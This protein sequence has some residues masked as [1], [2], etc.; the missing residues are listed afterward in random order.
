MD[1]NNNQIIRI[2]ES[3][4]KESMNDAVYPAHLLKAVLHHDFG[5]VE[6]LE[7]M[8]KDYY[9]ILDWADARIGLLNKTN[10][11]KSDLM[12]SDESVAVFDESDNYRLQFDKDNADPLCILASLC[13]P[14][15]GFSFEQ[16][17]TLPVTHSEIIANVAIAPKPGRGGPVKSA[18]G[19]SGY[20]ALNQYCIDKLSL[21]DEGDEEK[22]IGLEK[23]ILTIVEILG[24]K[25][26]S[27]VLIIGESGVGKTSLIKGFVQ[28]VVN[29]NIPD[30]LKNARIFELDFGELITGA[31]YKGE[32][33]DRFKKV[34]D[35][36]KTFEKPILVIESIENV[37]DKYGTLS[38][39]SGIIKQELNKGGFTIIGTCTVA[40]YTKNIE[41]DSDFRGKFEKIKFPEPSEDQS[42]RIISEIMPAY[43]KHHGVKAGE[44]VIYEAIRLS[45]RYLNERA[46]PSSA[47]DLLDRAMSLV[48]TMNKISSDEIKKLIEQCDD[49]SKK[50]K[51]R[52]EKQLIKKIDW[53]YQE[54]Y[55][56]ISRSLISRVEDGSDFSDI[57]N[58]DD[59]L[60]YIKNLLDKLT[61]IST[62]KKEVIDEYDLTIII[63]QLSGIPLGKISSKERDKL[64]NAED[65]LK[66]RVCGQNHAIKTIVEAIYEARSGLG[67]KG[68]PIGSFFFLGPTGTG[69]TELAK[70]LAEFLFQDESSMIRFDMSEFK[71]EHSAAL[72]IG[73][74]PGYVG[75]EEGGL[76]V[77]K[78][79][80][81]PYSVVLFDEI[82]KAH[83]SVFDIFLQI[84]DEG[85]L[86]DKLAREGDFSNALVL[87]TSNIGSD[88]IFKSFEENIIPD[89][90]KLNEIMSGRFRP[91]FLGRLTE[92]IPFGPI[93]EEIVVK[94]FEIHYRKLLATVNEMGIDLIINEETKTA[95]ANSGFSRQLGARP[96]IGVIRNS[97]RRPLSKL[98]ISGKIAK[99]SKI[100]LKLEDNEYKWIY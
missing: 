62:E 97:L 51:S 41:T 81:K 69:K 23:D 29:G 87:F 32:V 65:F 15:V 3:Y 22:I 5:L 34:A 42:F 66:K 2:A 49:L 64:I 95:L 12:L 96:I 10:T 90:A 77:N 7:K 70:T 46:Q 11:V 71:E 18:T 82:E 24:R 31:S 8:D 84:L 59:K 61:K 74:P 38:G 13:T 6:F 40:G 21:V 56:R 26:K 85:K 44:N 54:V 72:L 58:P 19:A 35:D 39:L 93:T 80:Q 4:A 9:Y 43:E 75:Y 14:G 98:L 76:L 99:G 67:K 27:N 52:D 100:E 88:F 16:L 94:I 36:I 63:S 28:R 37:F 17:K 1:D 79:R 45:K 20:K 73:A 83:P 50:S 78:I 55:D 92:I 30:F 60:S 57:K 89:S 68:Q 86:H 33:E 25:S 53:L 48:N 47:I 91:E